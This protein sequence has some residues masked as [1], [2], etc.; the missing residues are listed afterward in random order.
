MVENLT[1]DFSRDSDVGSDRDID[2]A[3]SQY[4]N[5]KRDGLDQHDKDRVAR[6]SHCEIER[7]RRNK[8]TAYINE[9]CEM[10]PTCSSLARKPDKLTILRMAVSH[11]KTMRGTGNTGLDGSYQPSFLSDEELK[12]LV[13]EAA[14]GFLFVCQCDTGRIIYVSDSVTTVLNQTQSEWYQHTLYELCHPGDAE[15]ICEQLTGAV[16]SSQ[17]ASIAG[18]TERSSSGPFTNC[19]GSTTPCK[20]SVP[21]VPKHSC[22][23]SV[24]PPDYCSNRLSSAHHQHLSPN[25]A[26][27]PVSPS[28]YPP[29]ILDLKTGTVKKDGQHSH[30]RAGMGARR[31]FICRMRVGSAIPGSSS[32]LDVRSPHC[33]SAATRTRLRHRQAFGPS[34]TPG[35]PSHVLVHV[36][37]FVR[38][39][40]SAHG[41]LK[42]DTHAINGRSAV[43]QP[44]TVFDG[45]AP[46]DVAF[47]IQNTG[48]N[49]SNQT[50]TDKLPDPQAPRCLVALARLQVN[51]RP[52]AVDL[53][54]YRLQEFFTRLSSDSRITFCDQR[55]QNVLGVETDDVL[56]RPFVDLLESNKEKNDFQEL[57]ERAWKFKGEVFSLIVTLRGKPTSDPVSVRCNLF[58][59]TNPFSEEVEYVVC[60]AISM[61]SFQN[62]SMAPF[63][64][65][66]ATVGRNSSDI[67]VRLGQQSSGAYDPHTIEQSHVPS[68]FPLSSSQML[69]NTERFD[70]GQCD[71]DPYWRSAVDEHSRFN[72][73]P[74]SHTQHNLPVLPRSVPPPSGHSMNVFAG[75]LPTHP[76]PGC[77]SKSDHEGRHGSAIPCPLDSRIPPTDNRKYTQSSELDYSTEVYPLRTIPDRATEH[78]SIGPIHFY[79]SPLDHANGS[80]TDGQCSAIAPTMM[81]EGCLIRSSNDGLNRPSAICYLPSVPVG[82]VGSGIPS[83]SQS[84]L[85]YTPSSTLPVGCTHGDYSADQPPASDTT[86]IYARS[87]VS[88]ST[89]SS[90]FHGWYPEHSL[91]HTSV[92]VSSSVTDAF[93]QAV[94]TGL[95]GKYQY[96][97]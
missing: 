24:S 28:T 46:E 50:E 51:N 60:T 12:H 91:D 11:M 15:K 65:S 71:S 9:L 74:P 62:P 72:P 3:S 96:Y 64:S 94:P 70:D 63:I 66:H 78:E 41:L 93:Q 17:G 16:L 14:D 76:N 77:T 38:P 20:T 4:S 84:S 22:Q 8:M 35:Q 45:Y 42:P 59:F 48:T 92:P 61:K 75:S 89:C 39:M 36:T 2:V 53:S 97:Y 68:T 56:G 87:P 81:N 83:P 43:S 54:P 52:D 49:G 88:D 31:G 19:G 10:V 21:T 47:G 26:V 55:V 13:L 7:R 27:G 86:N 82:D 40:G 34:Y 69:A 80:D 44:Y 73:L 29:R 57:F 95:R 23:G 33:T 32:L 85:H 1:S 18:L 37:G 67:A 25:G 5:C 90:V 30:S 58:G 6:E 79:T